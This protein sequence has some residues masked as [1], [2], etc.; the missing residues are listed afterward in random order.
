MASI[1]AKEFSARIEKTILGEINQML[2]LALNS[3]QLNAVSKTLTE[4]MTS[5]FHFESAKHSEAISMQK[6]DRNVAPSFMKNPLFRVGFASALIAGAFYLYKESNMAVEKQEKFTEALIEKQKEEA[7]F[8]PAM[9]DEFRGSYTDNVIYKLRYTEMK[10]DSG[11]Q[12]NWALNLNDFFLKELRLSEDNMVRFIGLEAALIKKLAT[13]RESLDSKYYEEGIA[14]MREAEQAEVDKIMAV[15]KTPQ[16]Y[17]RLRMRE[18]IFL[19][20]VSTVELRV[21]AN[22]E[23]PTETPAEAAPEATAPTGERT[24]QSIEAPIPAAI[25]RRAPPTPRAANGGRVHRR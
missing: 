19:S 24:P 10:M 22:Q 21:P 7:K 8:K 15:L 9:S 6:Q 14:R 5:M 23:T 16:N 18:K 12:D 4:E 17:Q 2:P 13:L 3:A 20:Q 25:P 1:K 11:I